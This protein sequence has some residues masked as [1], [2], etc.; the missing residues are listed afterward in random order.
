MD[1]PAASPTHSLGSLAS[2]GCAVTLTNTCTLP[3]L[4]V[5][6]H[7]LP[8]HLL[9]ATLIA[10]KRMGDNFFQKKSIY[11]RGFQ[12]CILLTLEIILGPCEN[13]AVVKFDY[14]VK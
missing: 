10:T 3:T 7:T 6:V 4:H 2:A 13:V 11:L 5:T 12:L 8:T 1:H 9:L 14:L